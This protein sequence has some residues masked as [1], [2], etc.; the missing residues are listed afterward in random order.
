MAPSRLPILFPHQT[1]RLVMARFWVC[2][3]GAGF[4]L[5]YL[6]LHSHICGSSVS[7]IVRKRLVGVWIAL[8]GGGLG[9]ELELVFALAGLKTCTGGRT[10]DVLLVSVLKRFPIF[11]SYAAPTTSSFCF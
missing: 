2:V 10:A 11:F 5:A 8:W 7:W 9:M 6:V 4:F 1:S 3:A